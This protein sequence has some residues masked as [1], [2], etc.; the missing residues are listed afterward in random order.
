MTSTP[1]PLATLGFGLQHVL[2][3]FAGIVTPPLVVAGSI[4]LSP[5]DSALLVAMALLTSG[6]TTFLQVRRIGPVGSG[7][8]AV[9]GTS[10]TFVPPAIQA[11]NSGGL[12]LVFGTALA[13]APVEM[14]LSK[15]IG[16]LRRWFPPVVTGTV[17]TLIGLNLVGVGMTD[18]AGGHGVDD[19]GAPRH[20]GLGLLV[21]TSIVALNRFGSGLVK[22]A[23][24]GLGIGLGYLVALA[25]GRVDLSGVASAP[26]V[27]LPQPLAFGLTIEPAYLVPFA[28]AYVVSAMETIGDL[29]AVSEAS[30]EPVD[31]PVFVDRL[32]GGLLAD[33]LGSA[34]A[35]LLNCLPNTTFSQ[36]VGVVGL[37]G[38]ATRS[39]GLAVAGLLVVLGLVPKLAAVISAM[40]KPVLGGATT[41]LFGTVAV[42]GLRIVTRD[43]FDAR[44]QLILA[45]SLA[46]GLGVTMVPAALTGWVAEGVLATSLHIVL[47]SGMAVGALVALGLN[48]LLPSE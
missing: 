19:L 10:F 39:V 43:G 47:T 27:A 26:W 29:T 22:A 13:T 38:V 44:K 28:I 34:L 33:G 35:A 37:T 9:Q 36:N 3:M 4:G 40:P 21:L 14:V 17:V 46:L 48:A 20:I 32:Q 1:S 2:A 18:L 42:G 30:G 11:G 5:E 23:S 45:V 24:I 6:L 31:G 41:V 15:L 16:P 25:L 7:L 12:A 8:L